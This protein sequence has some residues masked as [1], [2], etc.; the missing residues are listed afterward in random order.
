[1]RLMT[2]ICAGIAALALALGYASQALWAGAGICLAIGLLWLGSRL[3]GWD[4]AADPC[5][6]GWA[7][8]AAFGAWQGLPAS[9]LL[10][11]VV[12]ALA[13][14]DLD[15]FAARLRCAGVIAQR[16]ELGRAH[17]RQLAIVAG[18]GLLLGAIALSLRV[19]LTF[20]W[21]ILIA[22]LAIFSLSRM[23]GSGQSQQQ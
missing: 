21:A 19:D 15:H 8:M 16:A 2:P 3:R 6:A 12:A 5:L 11:A 10:L 17:L 7:G 18:I 9:L 4:W 1:M 23:I 22:T 13:A 14:W 20:G